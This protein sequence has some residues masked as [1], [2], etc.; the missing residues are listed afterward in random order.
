[1][2]KGQPGPPAGKRK[3][4]TGLFF[5]SCGLGLGLC[6]ALR[7]RADGW[8]GGRRLEGSV[9][10]LAEL[11]GRIC[12]GFITVGMR[13]EADLPPWHSLCPCGGQG[14][15]G[16]GRMGLMFPLNT[17]VSATKQGVSDCCPDRFN[18]CKISVLSFGQTLRESP[19][20]N[21]SREWLFKETQGI[22]SLC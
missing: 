13:N 14:R 20:T 9:Q 11:S 19:Q 7:E 4:N 12:E 16:Q 10:G 3:R 8:K 1:M 17:F 6:F 2:G 18:K 15:A 21:Q 22:K 5:Q